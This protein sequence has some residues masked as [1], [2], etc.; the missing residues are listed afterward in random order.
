[1]LPLPTSIRF[2]V[3][4]LAW[5][6]ELS[7]RLYLGLPFEEGERKFVD[8]LLLPGHTV[9]DIGAHHGLYTLQ[10]S[11]KVRT[12]GTVIAFEPSPRELKRLRWHILINRCNNVRVEPLALSSSDGTVGL[13]VC[14]SQQTGLNSMRPPPGQASC[15]VMVPTTTLDNYVRSNGIGT[16]DFLKVDVE[17]AELEVLKGATSVL[18]SGLPP[19][20]MCEIQ[21]IRTK[22]WGYDASD[23]RDLVETYGYEIFSVTK[24]GRLQE[25]QR[26]KQYEENLIFVPECRLSQ[27]ASLIEPP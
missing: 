8:N 16:I 23:I 10:A 22:E 27:V 24:E 13:F 21:D 11:K 17:G 25:C 15:L 2:G 19:I 4:W 26:K 6:D 20:I 3:T 18:S 14:L 1:V 5:D 7:G 9:F 12:G